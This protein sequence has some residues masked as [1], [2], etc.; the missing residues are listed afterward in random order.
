MQV[1]TYIQDLLYRYEC[2]IIPGFGAFLTQY[3]SANLNA[4]TH[5]FT[6]PLKTV[7]FNRQL[8]T[9]DGLLANYI[10]TVQGES[11]EHA[12]Q[13][14]RDF[15]SSCSKKLALGEEV[16]LFKIGKFTLSSEQTI[17][18][19]PVNAENFNTASFGLTTF[20]SGQ[21]YREDALALEGTSEEAVLLFTP[22]ARRPYLKYVAVGLIAL[23]V[24]GLGGMKLYEGNVQQ[25]NLVQKQKAT[26][27][28]QNQIQEATFIINSPL[29]TITIPLKK[30]T[31]NYH[32]VAGAFR[33]AANADKK[34]GQLKEKGY[35]PAMIGKNKYGLHQVVY[36]SH[37]DRLE[38]LKNLRDIKRTENSDAWLLIKK[39]Q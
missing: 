35:A 30:Q 37:N 33:E 18:F 25:Y 26:T 36:S 15:A 12:L 10:A 13:K 7:S 5:T 9:N 22:R 14:V 8:Q 32:I 31:G 23:A 6:P 24:A 19:E 27:K 28:V 38:A 17:Q 2:V 3:N 34:M 16:I 4:E 21:V 29:P 1:S 11:Y 39:L 20:V